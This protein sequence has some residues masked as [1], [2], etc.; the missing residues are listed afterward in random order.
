MS[1]GTKDEISPVPTSSGE[2]AAGGAGLGSSV[3]VAA[4]VTGPRIDPVPNGPTGWGEASRGSKSTIG[5]VMND[6]G[7][8]EGLLRDTEGLGTDADRREVGQTRGESS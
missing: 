7:R 8:P 1:T 5:G 4:A 3:K 6:P 2:S